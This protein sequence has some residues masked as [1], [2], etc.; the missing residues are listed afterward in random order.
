MWKK[1]TARIVNSR[2]RFNSF[3]VNSNKGLRR[4]FAIC[5]SKLISV[6]VSLRSIFSPVLLLCW[7]LF[8][9]SESFFQEFHGHWGELL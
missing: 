6:S 3:P 7:F 1:H 4:K 9:P 8:S 5:I 2:Q